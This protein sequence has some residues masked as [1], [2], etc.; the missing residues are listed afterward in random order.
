MQVGTLLTLRIRYELAEGRPDKAARTLQIGFAMARHV[1][2]EPTLISA[3]VG[4][5]FAG[6]MENRLEEFVQQPDAPNLYWSLTDLPRPFIDL[7]KANARRASRA[8]TAVSPAWPKRPP[9]S[10]PS[11]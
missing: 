7:R 3:L 5:A 11:R 8:P 1:A 9:T 6:L 10:T 2:E 4:M